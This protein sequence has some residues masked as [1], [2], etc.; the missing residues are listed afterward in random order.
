M[1]LSELG[2]GNTQVPDEKTPCMRY[3]ISVVNGKLPCQQG[4]RHKGQNQKQGPDG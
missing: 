4:V 3:Q 1:V 2:H